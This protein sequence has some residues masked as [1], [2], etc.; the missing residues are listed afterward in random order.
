MNLIDKFN[1]NDPVCKFRLNKYEVVLSTL[2]VN[3]LSLAL[4]IMVLQVYDRIMINRSVGTLTVLAIGVSIAIILEGILRIARAYTTSWAGMMYEYTMAANAMRLYINANPVKLKKEGP[5]QQI[6]NLNAFSKLRDF[7]SGQTLIN[8]VDIPFAFTFLVLISYLTGKLVIVPIALIAIF[9][10]VTWFL[11]NKL[12]QSLLNQGGVDDKRYNFI[13][14]ALQGI[15]TIKSLGLEA[16][17]T[18]RYASLEEECSIHNYRTALIST[19]GYT[20]GILFNEL[21]VVAIV[22]FGAPMVIKGDFTSGALVATVLLAGRLMQPIQKTLF[23]WTQFQE[24]RIANNQAEKMFSIEQVER[25]PIDNKEFKEIGTVKLE[26]VSFGY[27]EKMVFKNINLDLKIPDTIGIRGENNAGKATLMRLI[28]GIVKP[29]SGR[30][31]VN[32]IPP[33]DYQSEEVVKYIGYISAN[34]ILFQGTIL[35]NLTAFNEN[36][37]NEALE[38]AKMFNLDKEIALL[39]KGYDTKINDGI[40]DIIAPGIKQRIAI[41]RA[42]IHKPKIILFH[43]A[44]RGLDKEGYNLLIKF[45]HLINNQT[46]T[47]IVTEDHNINLLVDREYLLKDGKLTVINSQDSRIYDLKPYKELKI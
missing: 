29:T 10:I 45:L 43:N 7:Y 11:G 36:M 5:G 38:I 13:V 26:N 30:I 8:I 2:A 15:H 1:L 18:R 34:N 41:S 32:G 16:I 9:T 35:E 12:K 24:Y 20:F 21:M 19:Q 23:L 37:E 46:T 14:E 17:F 25:R 31:F 27:G 28:A 47:I 3:L 40:A 44:D 39:P 42:L 22:S 33:S 6:Q 4:P